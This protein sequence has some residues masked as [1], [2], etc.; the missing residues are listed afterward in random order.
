MKDIL[1]LGRYLRPYKGRILMAVAASFISTVFLS[2]FWVLASSVIRDTLTPPAAAVDLLDAGRAAPPSRPAHT[3]ESAQSPGPAAPAPAASSGTGALARMRERLVGLR[4]VLADA[5]GF[6]AFR[7]WLRESP[8]TRLPPVIVILFLLKG[9]FTYF[10]EY[11]LKWVGYRTIQDLRLDLFERVLGQSTR[12][13]PKYPT[14]VLMSRVMG[15]GGRLQKVAST[16]LAD[17]VRLSFTVVVAVGF[18]FII[19]WQLSLACFIGMPLIL[20][21]LAR[22]G[23]KLKSSSP[24]SQERAAEV[25]N[26][27]NE[28]IS[29]NRIVKAFGMEA[30]ELSRF[31]AA[32]VRMF[33]ADARAQRVVAPP[34]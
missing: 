26:V 24:W 28:S 3:E 16:D 20:V 1:R 21:P 30:F 27:L 10:A 5:L 31:K 9:V 8:F 15:D 34:S 14:G 29:G 7:R 12:F 22:F 2:G 25:S 11:W 13:Y 18:V 33:R 17:A 32:L 4:D 19:S 6:T 23:R